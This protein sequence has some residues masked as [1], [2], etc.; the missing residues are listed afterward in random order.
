[1]YLEK[2]AVKSANFL[3][4]FTNEINKTYNRKNLGYDVDYTKYYK[5]TFLVDYMLTL[6]Y[7]RWRLKNYSCESCYNSIDYLYGSLYSS[8]DPKRIIDCLRCLFTD[9]RVENYVTSLGW[10]LEESSGISDM[11]IV[12]STTV[13]LTNPVVTYKLITNGS[14]SKFIPASSTVNG[15]EF[16]CADA[17]FTF[18]GIQ[19]GL[20]IKETVDNLYLFYNAFN[21]N[22][23][24][25]T[26]L[27]TRIDDA[28]L[29]V[30]FDFY[31]NPEFQNPCFNACEATYK[32]CNEFPA[33]GGTWEVTKTGCEVIKGQCPCEAPIFTVNLK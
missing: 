20:T 5:A 21:I 22:F 25:T 29:K 33:L 13:S 7:E 9:R 18:N 10:I 1:M 15:Q 26:F 2:F 17:D 12:D 27:L 23:G 8:W 31:N 32:I 11:C 14:K 24:T 28:T 6:E 4:Q 16:D 19:Y 30:E 3:N